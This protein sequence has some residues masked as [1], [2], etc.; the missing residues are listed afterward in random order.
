MILHDMSSLGFSSHRNYIIF[1][2]A[3]HDSHLPRPRFIRQHESPVYDPPLVATHLARPAL[4]ANWKRTNMRSKTGICGDLRT[5]EIS[6][7]FRILKLLYQSN[8]SLD[9]LFHLYT[10]KHMSHSSILLTNRT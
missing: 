1:A 4:V 8:L 3:G 6:S 5:N 10:N 2:H 7:E 9:A